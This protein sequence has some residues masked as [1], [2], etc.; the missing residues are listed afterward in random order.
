MMTEFEGFTFYRDTLGCYNL[1]DYSI[2]TI[3]TG[4]MY[5]GDKKYGEYIEKA[6]SNS[7]L[8]NRLSQELRCSPQEIQKVSLLE[9]VRGGSARGRRLSC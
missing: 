7:K 9:C 3:L 5:F 6:Y 8:F 1:T 4:E 2:P